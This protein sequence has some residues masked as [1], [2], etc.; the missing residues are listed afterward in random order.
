MIPCMGA[1]GNLSSDGGGGRPDAC[2]ELSVVVVS[3][4]HQLSRCGV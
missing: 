1:G 2:V 4:P 3:S